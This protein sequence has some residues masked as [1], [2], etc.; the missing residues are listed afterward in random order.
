MAKKDKTNKVKKI[1]AS[2]KQRGAAKK[3]PKDIPRAQTASAGADKR[4][5]IKKA[6]AKWK[7]MTKAEHAAAQPQGR[8][9]KKPGMGGS[10]K[11]YRVV[12]RPKSEFKIFRVHDVGKKG[13]VERVAGQRVNGRWATQAWLIDKNEAHISKGIL[14]GDKKEVKDVLAKLRRKPRFLKG[15]IF[16]AGPRVNVPERLK[17]TLASS[18]GV[19]RKGAK[20]VRT[21]NI[22]KARAKKMGKY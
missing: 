11:F 18:K 21:K 2:L 12:V 7:S 20:K 5:N 6:W 10:G 4:G 14:V 22:K 16:E 17:S 3:A 15:D 1:K 13:H 19:P 8:G 9:R